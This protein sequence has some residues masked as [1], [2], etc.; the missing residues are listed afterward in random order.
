MKNIVM[1]L[2]NFCFV[3]CLCCE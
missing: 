1:V 3:L 2:Y